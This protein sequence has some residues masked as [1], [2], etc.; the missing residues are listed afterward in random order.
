MEFM[1]ISRQRSSFTLTILL[2][3][4]TFCFW[5]VIRMFLFGILNSIWPFV[6]PA[7]WQHWH[8]SAPLCDVTLRGIQPQQSAIEGDSSPIYR[9]GGIWTK[10]EFLPAKTKSRIFETSREGEFKKILFLIIWNKIHIYYVVYDLLYEAL[11]SKKM[12]SIYISCFYYTVIYLINEIFSTWFIYSE[13]IK[14]PPKNEWYWN[15]LSKMTIL[16]KN[17]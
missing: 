15:Y 11:F 17:I 10:E 8:E 7:E 9:F 13:K 14:A 5:T 3:V 4:I 16:I 12:Y 1:F 2:V 6:S